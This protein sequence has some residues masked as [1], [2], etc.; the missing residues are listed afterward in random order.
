MKQKQK[1][2]EFVFWSYDLFPYMLGSELIELHDNGMAE[3]KGYGGMRFRPIKILPLKEGLEIHEEI[4]ELKEL[5]STL[6]GQIEDLC[7]AKLDQIARFNKG[8]S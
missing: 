3:P 2:R 1:Q 7:Q 5:R 6:L 8:K 4:V